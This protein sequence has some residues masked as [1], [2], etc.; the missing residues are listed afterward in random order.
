LPSRMRRGNRGRFFVRS[1]KAAICSRGRHGTLFPDYLSGI[2]GG[3]D[4]D[5][6]LSQLAQSSPAAWNRAKCVDLAGLD[7]LP[8]AEAMIEVRRTRLADFGTARGL[9]RGCPPSGIRADLRFFGALPAQTGPFRLKHS[10]LDCERD[11]WVC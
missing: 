9:P 7:A 5:A 1:R 3:N 10:I 2:Y 11:L 4:A 8:L 6:S